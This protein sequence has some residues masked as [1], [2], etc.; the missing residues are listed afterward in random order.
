MTDAGARGRFVWHDLLTP[1]PAAAVPFYTRLLGWGTELWSMEGT[2]PYTMW[3]VDAAA[4]GGVM[5]MPAGVDAPAHWLSYLC[6]GD[7]D[8][9]ARQVTALGGAV[10]R[11]PSAIATVGRFAVVADP[12]GAAFALFTPTGST[13][14]HEGPARV[15]EVSWHELATPDQH[16]AAQF[17][18]EVAGWTPGDAHDV[19]AM[20]TY[21]I[22]ERHGVPFGGICR[23]PDHAPARAAWTIYVRVAS[24]RA[25]AERAA[26]LGGTVTHGPADVPG[27]ARV[28]GCCDPTGASFV[29]HEPPA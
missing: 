5:A 29:M 2:P 18:A 17:Y 9:A 16:A 3:T 14:G 1:D 6:V 15:G 22:L 8:A 11:E 4:I 27:G 25:V 7:T 28:A 23:R 13:P 12:Q 20:G 19:G 10:L 21:R 24:V 26:A